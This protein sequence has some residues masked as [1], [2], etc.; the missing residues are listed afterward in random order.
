MRKFRRSHW[1]QIAT[2]LAV[3]AL[4]LAQLW[5]EQ[6]PKP[7][8]SGAEEQRPAAATLNNGEYRV[9]RVVDGD[10]LLLEA[11]RSRLRLQ[12]VDTPETVKEDAP[13]AAWGPEATEF[14]QR[15]VNDAGGQVRVEVDGEATDQYGRYL[16]FVW[17]GQQMLN[18]ELVRAGL[19]KAKLYYDYS[20]EKK[21]RLRRA[22]REAERAR[23]G[24]W[25]ADGAQRRR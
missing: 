6:S 11:P 20:Q 12:G 10:T 22:Q 21:D 4:V 8:R 19:A 17:H 24:I 14:T 3:L 15:F 7:E 5:S 25:S 23:R 13:I 2:A 18:E 16:G 1:R 9:E